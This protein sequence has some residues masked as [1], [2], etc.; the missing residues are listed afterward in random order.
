MTILFVDGVSD[1]SEIGIQ[2]DEQG[3]PI[4]LINGSC[5]IHRRLPLKQGVAASLLLFGKNV[6]QP[7]VV[8]KE[9]PSLIFNQIAD[10]DTHRGALERCIDLCNQV[11]TTIINHP[12]H[13]LETTRDGVSRMLQGIP[14]VIVPRI[15]RFQP[16]SPDEVFSRAASECF[17]FPFIMRATGNHDGSNM[18]KVEGRADYEAMH[19]FPFDGRHYYLCEYVDYRDEQG[20][21][22]KQRI[23]VIDGDP[24]VRHSLFNSDWNIHGSSRNFMMARESW[25]E[26]Q[27]RVDRVT[28]EFIPRI[29]TA[30][31]EIT[32]RLKLEY[33]GIDCSIRPDGTLIVFEA[34]AA[35]NV[36]NNE[37]PVIQ[38]RVD[39]IGERIRQLLTQYSGERVI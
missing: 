33:Y 38:Y 27:A 22:H 10:A 4:Y 20:L 30:I 19:A 23:V 7:A 13:I 18:I 32:R 16:R 25:E 8:F 31:D 12:R 34:N 3:R 5:S 29:R 24:L 28:N 14:G 26:E 2:L 9:Q 1:L 21:H 15:Q 6:R 37:Y 39:A 17:D 36:L 11:N 35:M